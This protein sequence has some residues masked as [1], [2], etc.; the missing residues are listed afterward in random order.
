[1][2]R[3]SRVESLDQGRFSGSSL[4]DDP[5][6]ARVTMAL[7]SEGGEISR[8]VTSGAF[9]N[10]TGAQMMNWLAFMMAQKKEGGQGTAPEP[11]KPEGFNPA[12]LAPLGQNVGDLAGAFGKKDKDEKK[13]STPAKE[14]AKAADPAPTPEP[15]PKA[16]EQPPEKAPPAQEPKPEE[17]KPKV[18]EEAPKPA[19]TKAPVKPEKP[20]AAAKPDAKPGDPKAKQDSA[21]A[22][23]A[24]VKPIVDLVANLF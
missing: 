23:A 13:E 24:L 18:E 6:L 9:A 3:S 19:E 16:A 1:M 14:P 15:Q 5:V 10:S 17:A 21:D 22:V 11:A 4:D 20:E 2:A 8:L 12:A 7:A